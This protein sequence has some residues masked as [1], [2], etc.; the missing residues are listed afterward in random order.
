M[1]SLRTEAK[2]FPMWKRETPPTCNLKPL[3]KK[4]ISQTNLF[5]WAF[6][7]SERQPRAQGP[8]TTRQSDSSRWNLKRSY[9]GACVIFPLLRVPTD[10]QLRLID[11]PTA[12]SR[13][14]IQSSVAAADPSELPTTV[15]RCFLPI[16]V[17]G[18]QGLYS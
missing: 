15:L 17:R 4:K 14:G 16:A 7:V 6:K 12:S 5:D 8:A 2:D 13:G 9:L 10:L 1:I 11:Q 3:A 18:V